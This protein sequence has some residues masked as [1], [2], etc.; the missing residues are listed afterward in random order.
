MWETRST[1]SASAHFSVH[2]RCV[3]CR[4][5]W[6]QEDDSSCSGTGIVQEPYPEERLSEVNLISLNVLLSRHEQSSAFCLLHNWLI[7]GKEVTYQ[8]TVIM[9]RKARPTRPRSLSK[10]GISCT[11]GSRAVTTVSEMNV[12]FGEGSAHGPSGSRGIVQEPY[13][14]KEEAEVDLSSLDILLS[15]HEQSSALSLA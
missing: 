6:I 11:S 13:L 8:S 1:F 12:W 14:E 7:K 9:R 4:K 10:S 5:A 3:P 2:K 15:R